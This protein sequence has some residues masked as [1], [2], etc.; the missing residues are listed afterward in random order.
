MNNCGIS[1]EFQGLTAKSGDIGAVIRQVLW[2]III[3]GGQEY[4]S[5]AGQ[6]ELAADSRGSRACVEP[7]CLNRSS[8][9]LRGRQ[10]SPLLEENRQGL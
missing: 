1:G 3:L 8:H 7:G 2:S 5:K 4:A 6:E 9:V 10:S